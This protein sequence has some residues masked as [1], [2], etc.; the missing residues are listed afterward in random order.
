MNFKTFK[1]NGKHINLVSKTSKFQGKSIDDIFRTSRM[2]ITSN[3]VV[4]NKND[5]V[6]SSF[7]NL[8]GRIF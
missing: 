7:H 6:Q 5:F 4:L 2:V 1:S 3:T 8:I